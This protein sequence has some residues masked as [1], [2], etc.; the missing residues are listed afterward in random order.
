M[1]GGVQEWGKKKLVFGC[2]SLQSRHWS[3]R[4]QRKKRCPAHPMIHSSPRDGM[5]W[6]DRDGTGQDRIHKDGQTPSRWQRTA[7]IRRRQGAPPFHEG[8]TRQRMR[9]GSLRRQVLRKTRGRAKI[10]C[11]QLAR[12]G[13]LMRT[14]TTWGCLGAGLAAAAQ[15]S[16]P[17]PDKQG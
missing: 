3:W 9:T 13:R 4:R 16:M 8:D 14:W 5:G 6:V 11:E 2:R 7:Q 15:D 12:C 1:F 17:P 10:L